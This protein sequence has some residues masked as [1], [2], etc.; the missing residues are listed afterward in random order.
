VT[1]RPRLAQ[2]PAFVPGGR[3]QG[4]G[5]EV[6]QD[7]DSF[8]GREGNSWAVMRMT[9]AS[10]STS[11]IDRVSGPEVKEEGLQVEGRYEASAVRLDSRSPTGVGGVG[12]GAFAETG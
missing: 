8:G 1:R 2:D 12:R 3:G 6:P 9:S 11:Q 7:G 5:L 4:H 10:A